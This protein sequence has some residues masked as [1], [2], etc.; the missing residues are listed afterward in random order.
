[1]T[2]LSD[3]PIEILLQIFEDADTLHLKQVCHGFNELIDFAEAIN[4]KYWST[5]LKILESAI[6]KVE[7]SVVPVNIIQ[8]LPRNILA[9]IIFHFEKIRYQE[10]LGTTHNYQIFTLPDNETWQRIPNVP[11]RFE[12]SLEYCCYGIVSKPKKLELNQIVVFDNAKQICELIK[13]NDITTAIFMIENYHRILDGEGT[14]D[15]YNQILT[16]C[17]YLN[18]FDTYKKIFEVVDS[19]FIYARR[20]HLYYFIKNQNLE[21]IQFI[22]KRSALITE[23]SVFESA[24]KIC[25]NNVF[26]KYIGCIDVNYYEKIHNIT[27]TSNVHNEHTH[28]GFSDMSYYETF[29]VRLISFSIM[30]DNLYAFEKLLKNNFIIQI[31]NKKF[32]IYNEINDNY[33]DL[34]LYK[35]IELSCMFNKKFLQSFNDEKNILNE[36]FLVIQNLQMSNCQIAKFK[37]EDTINKR[38]NQQPKFNNKSQ[39]VRTFNKKSYR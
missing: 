18:N 27:C 10:K 38:K 8:L 21:A 15:F 35:A 1:M 39:Y 31:L 30:Y 2:S 9:D 26:D 4:G 29:Y 37:K 7:F 16:Y 5:S 34:T 19:I 6:R 13:I 3:F 17:S 24:I 12:L 23:R 33:A 11:L 25:A 36:K 22:L 32:K 28:F 14:G 20:D